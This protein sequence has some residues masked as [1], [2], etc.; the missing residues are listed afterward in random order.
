MRMHDCPA[1]GAEEHRGPPHHR[2]CTAAAAAAAL[3]PPNSLP[4]RRRCRRMCAAYGAGA[5]AH[6]YGG[7]GVVA[8]AARGA[9]LVTGHEL[10]AEL[11]VTLRDPPRDSPRDPPHDPPPPDSPP[12]LWHSLCEQALADGQPRSLDLPAWVG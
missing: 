1:W 6:T 5:T 7:V 11:H 10:R 2:L 4:P 8:G 9:R 3:A 12:D